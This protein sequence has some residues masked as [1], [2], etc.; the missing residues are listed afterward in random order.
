[1]VIIIKIVLITLFPEMP[2]QRHLKYN[3]AERI[4]TIIHE[5]FY[6]KNAYILLV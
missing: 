4:I 3:I 6:L 5:L 1:M 2:A